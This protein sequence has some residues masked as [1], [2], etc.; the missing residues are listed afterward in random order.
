MVY[1]RDCQW[2]KKS[3]LHKLS[4]GINLKSANQYYFKSIPDSLRSPISR[5]AVKRTSG[6]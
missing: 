1:S 4:G 2:I 3:R 6:L 5:D